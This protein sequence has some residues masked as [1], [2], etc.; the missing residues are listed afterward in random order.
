MPTVR[1]SHTIEIEFP[2]AELVRYVRADAAPLIAQALGV[3]LGE[4]KLDDIEV[5]FGS[6]HRDGEGQRY[7]G[8]A[9]Y[10]APTKESSDG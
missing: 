9:R 8:V 1:N 5:Y 4:V 2:Q 6:Q 3:P 7:K 10:R